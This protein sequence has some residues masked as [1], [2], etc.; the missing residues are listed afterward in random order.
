MKLNS[1]MSALL[2]E[3]GV[4]IPF[5][6]GLALGRPES[7]SFEIAEGSVVL[8]TEYDKNRHVNISDFPD[9]TGFETFINHVHLP[10][11]GTRESL[12]DC[13]AYVDAL[14]RGLIRLAGSRHFQV[15]VSIAEKDCTVR[16]HQVRLGE[17]WIA[18]NL[19]GYTDEA[20]LVLDVP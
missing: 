18:A 3:T 19:E 14:Q 12:L 4:S 9:R 11:S 17:R 1:K 15:I 10:F 8:R 2:G 20:I 5:N 6:D 13:L 7:P 16:F